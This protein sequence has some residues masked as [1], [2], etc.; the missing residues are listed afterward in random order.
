MA[1]VKDIIV[2]LRNM[3]SDIQD[4]DPLISKRNRR[5]R[6]LADRSRPIVHGALP[7]LG[8]RPKPKDERRRQAR[9]VRDARK[10]GR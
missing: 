7:Y 5:A 8:H 6:E 9:V 2:R 10:R 1:S 3:H 4:A